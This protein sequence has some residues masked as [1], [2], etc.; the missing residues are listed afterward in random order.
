MIAEVLFDVRPKEEYSYG[1]DEK[2]IKVPEEHD[3]GE[4]PIVV[5]LFNDIIRVVF[6][7]LEKHSL[8]YSHELSVPLTWI[9]ALHVSWV[10]EQKPYQH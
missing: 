9:C 6:P 5:I 10:D 8:W 1:C 4:K 2:V 7:Q 3:W